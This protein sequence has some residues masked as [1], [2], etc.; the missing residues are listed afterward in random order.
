MSIASRMQAGRMAVG[1]ITR[2]QWRVLAATNLSWLFD[3]YETYTLILVIGVALPQLLEPAQRARLPLYA[4]TVIALTLLGW[5]FGGLVGGVL[6]DYLGRKRAMMLAI[7]AYSVMTGLTAL[8]FSWW[9]FAVLRFLTGVA[10][11]SE[12]GTGTSLLAEAWPHRARAKAAG[13]MQAGFG[14][15]FFASA[16]LWFFLSAAGPSAWRWMFV[17]GVLPA[18]LVLWLQKRV[19]ESSLWHDA[20][21]RREEVRQK[22]AAGERLTQ[23]EGAY[24]RFTLSALLGSPRFRRLAF[25][26]ALM[27]LATTLGW[28]GVSTWVPSYIAQA[29]AGTGMSVARLAGAAGMA[30]NAGGV[31]GYLALGFIADALGRRGTV[32]IYM[33]GA[34]VMTPVLFLWSHGVALLL[35]FAC[36]HGFFSLGQF[37]WLPIW[38]P[39]FFP[40][41]I[42]GTAVA[43]VFN[44]PRFVA[45]VGPLIAGT[46][47]AWAHGFGLAATL[48]GLIY[49]VGLVVAPF[50][51]ETKDAPLPEG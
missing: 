19:T 26:G 27:S 45:W 36:V 39:E 18:L 11:G 51:P 4:G 10:I 3:G 28:W 48:V 50:S 41:H 16:L 32:I 22:V 20:S 47:I 14:L 34:L 17:V 49:V 21:R 31:I 43:F 9:A 25:L 44:T 29:G 13:V 30:Y 1:G 24:A 42:R 37:S 12:W 6:A 8:A 35:L 33:A 23:A 38:A 40:T 15:G 7:L 2:E 5:G 46:V